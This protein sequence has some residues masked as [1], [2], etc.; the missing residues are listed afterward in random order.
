MMSISYWKN[1]WFV[2]VNDTSW[3]INQQINIIRLMA[4]FKHIFCKLWISQMRPSGIS[5]WAFKN[6]KRSNTS[7]QPPQ[8]DTT[9]L[10][11]V[12]F[13]GTKW[14]QEDFLPFCSE[15]KSWDRFKGL[16]QNATRSGMNICF[17]GHQVGKVLLFVFRTGCKKGF[18]KK[19]YSN[20]SIDSYYV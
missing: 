1:I 19:S 4:T 8:V 9:Q 13:C 14:G 6:L 3:N 5:S 11:D 7:S 10:D 20:N 15:V 18:E 12:G 17:R 16:K 2:F